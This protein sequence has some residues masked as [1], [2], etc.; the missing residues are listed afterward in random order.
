MV[1]ALVAHVVDDID[2]SGLGVAVVPSIL[3]AQV[4]RDESCLPVVGEEDHLVTIFALPVDIQNQWCLHG[5]ETEQSEAME[6]VWILAAVVVVVEPALSLNAG[7]LNEQEVGPLALFVILAQVPV[8]DVLLGVIDPN[9]GLAD[10]GNPFKVL[11]LRGNH[12]GPMTVPC[13]LEGIG[14][15]HHAKTSRLRVWCHLTGHNNDGDAEI[16]WVVVRLRSLL[17]L[18]MLGFGFGISH[19][20]QS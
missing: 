5:S 12:H 10:V 15:C 7:P 17:P 11:V 14:S 8:L 18:S 9:S 3:V 20:C 16:V 13:K 19:G 2:A 1:L 4:E 6:V